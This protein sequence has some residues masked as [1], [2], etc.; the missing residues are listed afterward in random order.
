[1]SFVPQHSEGSGVPYCSCCN[2]VGHAQV[3]VGDALAALFTLD[4]A[5]IVQYCERCC[6]QV[7]EMNAGST[8]P[9]VVMLD[10]LQLVHCSNLTFFA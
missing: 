4:S 7:A 8:W 9:M 10:L 6:L 1:V 5:V 3:D 2:D